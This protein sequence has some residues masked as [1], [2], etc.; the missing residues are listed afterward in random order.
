MGI[1]G[2]SSIDDD[3]KVDGEMASLSPS[4]NRL[5]QGETCGFQ[6]YRAKGVED[7]VHGAAILGGQAG[8]REFQ[9]VQQVCSG[10]HRL[11]RFLGL[12]IRQPLGLT[13]FFCSLGEILQISTTRFSP[14]C[15]WFERGGTKGLLA[16]P[17]AGR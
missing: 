2:S 4:D 6:G 10:K 14:L 5:F 8:F 9:A 12:E 7:R 13:A 11:A 16:A 15:S 17:A 1:P 3:L